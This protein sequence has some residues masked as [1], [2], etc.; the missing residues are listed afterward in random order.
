[1]RARRYFSAESTHGSE[2]SMGFGN[3]T[4]VYVF[5]SKLARDNYVRDSR[6]ISCRAIKRYQVTNEAANYSLTRNTYN[7]PRPFSTE[8]WGITN[9]RSRDWEIGGL[10]GAVEVCIPGGCPTATERLF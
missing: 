6:N 2:S 3:D 9:W 7:R 10:V 1:M 5:S 4:V 8:F